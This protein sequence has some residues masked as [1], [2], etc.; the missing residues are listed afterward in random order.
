MEEEVVDTVKVDRRARCSLGSEN[1]RRG[2]WSS[3][4]GTRHTHDRGGGG[5]AVAGKASIELGEGTVHVG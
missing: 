5:G 2:T 3:G 4:I 1:R